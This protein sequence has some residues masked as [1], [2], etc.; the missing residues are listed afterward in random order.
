MFEERWIQADAPDVDCKVLYGRVC[1][2]RL[3]GDTTD[4]RQVGQAETVLSESFAGSAVV[5]ETRGL[6]SMGLAWGVRRPCRDVDWS[7]VSHL[8]IG[9]TLFLHNLKTEIVKRV[10]IK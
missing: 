3:A 9:I 5:D 1:I 6:G 7:T 8:R 4:A 2:H 10:I